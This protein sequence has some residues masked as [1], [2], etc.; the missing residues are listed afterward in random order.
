MDDLGGNVLD[1]FEMAMKRIDDKKGGKGGGLKPEER[2]F[3]LRTG[4][5]E[6]LHRF[7]PLREERYE[8]LEKQTDGLNEKQPQRR[9]ARGNI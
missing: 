4:L 1:N 3:E 2:D 8:A 6:T 7:I 5:R 9:I